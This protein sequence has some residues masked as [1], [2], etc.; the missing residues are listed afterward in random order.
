MLCLMAAVYIIGAVCSFGYARIMVQISQTCVANIRADLFGRMQRLPL[1]YFDAH[2]HG[3]LMSRYT[4]DIETISEALNNSFGSVV[5][6]TLNFLGTIAMMLV[7]SPV[8]TLITFAV[9][10]VMLLVVRTIGGR[11]RQ[12]FAAQQ[13]ALGKVNGYIEEMYSGHDVIRLSRAGRKVEQTFSEL[14][15]AVY[16]ANWKSQFLSGAMQPLMNVIGNLGYVVVC[17]TGSALVL[18]GQISFGVIVAFILYVRLFTSPLT[19]LAQGMTNMQTAAAAGDRVFD[20]LQEEELSDESGKREGLE[21]VRGEVEFDHVRFAYPSNL[22]KVI[23]KDF[24]AH[25]NPGQKVAIV[26]PTGA[27]KTTLVKLLTGLYDDYE[28]EILIDGKELREYSLGELKALSAVVYQDFCRYPLSLYG[29]IAIGN[30]R[31]M[32]DGQKVREAVERIGLS[33]A[34]DALPRKMETPVTKAEEGG[35]DLSGGEWQKVALARLLVSPAVI[36]I[37]DEPT[38]A[39]DPVAEGRVYEEFAK[40]A[41]QARDQGGVVIFISHRLASTKLADE[42]VV[43]ADGAVAEKGD[44]ATLMQKRGIYYEMF[45]SQR[46]W[47]Q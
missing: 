40:T 39:L 30:I 38:A 27:G 33:Q 11:S 43:V 29:N 37:L 4:N 35:V 47:Y 32:G 31:D 10:A 8:L 34:V 1:K 36:K 6:C 3:E 21:T 26:G 41:G 12:Y 2:T 14:N 23:I 24:S 25:I 16:E 45:E 28:G 18:D 46:K 9:L 19:T 44:F 22:D 15:Q 5:S 20:F 42:I 17:V 7:L 13:K